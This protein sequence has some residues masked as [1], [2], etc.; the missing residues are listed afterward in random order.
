[1]RSAA[2]TR[3]VNAS[4]F[5]STDAKILTQFVHEPTKRAKMTFE[6]DVADYI[7][8]NRAQQQSTHSITGFVNSMFHI[9][10]AWIPCGR[11]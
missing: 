8:L 5:E 4:V 3:H 9:I 1:M 2:A 7:R 11:R 6:D 10:G